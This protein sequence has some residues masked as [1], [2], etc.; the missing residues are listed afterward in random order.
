LSRL[1]DIVA[2][3]SKQDK[4]L[5]KLVAHELLAC[6][7]MGEKAPGSRVIAEW[8]SHMGHGTVERYQKTLDP[9]IDACF[10]RRARG[11]GA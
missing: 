3:K 4:A 10:E 6:R 11:G 1:R 9:M 2:L 8:C 7:H 5:M